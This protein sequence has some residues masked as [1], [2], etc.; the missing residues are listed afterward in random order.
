MYTIFGMT[1]SRMDTIVPVGNV[2]ILY[3]FFINTLRINYTD[4]RV[5]RIKI[6]INACTHHNTGV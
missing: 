6:F 2:Y 1:Y 5:Q 3:F 4:T